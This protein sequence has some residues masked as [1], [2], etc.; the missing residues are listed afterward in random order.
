VP[1]AGSIVH[2]NGSGEAAT[3]EALSTPRRRTEHDWQSVPTQFAVLPRAAAVVPVGISKHDGRASAA[4]VEP[5]NAE[6]RTPVRQTL[7]S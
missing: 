1:A 7:L 4:D 5:R 6:P 3:P 2:S